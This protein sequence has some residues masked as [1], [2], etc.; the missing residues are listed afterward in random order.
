MLAHDETGRGEPLVLL[1]G[2]GSHRA[3]FA[4]VIG[5]LAEHAS[6]WAIDLPGFGGSPPLAHEAPTVPALAAAVAGF[7]RERG[8][9]SFHVAGNS[10]GGGVALELGR[11]GVARTVCALSPIG[12][13]SGPELRYSRASLR[14]SRALARRLGA[15]RRMLAAT[16]AGRILAG[17]QYFRHPSRIP[18]ADFAA[19][20][21]ALAECPG[22]EATLRCAVG[23]PLERPEALRVPI[24]VAWAEHDRLL[25]TRTQA[26]RARR[27]LPQARHTLLRGCGHVPTYDDPAQVAAVLRA[28]MAARA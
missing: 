15:R 5:H 28:A 21:D 4:P 23:A 27:R 12:F 14:T 18:A 26:G 19:A 11:M 7:L 8:L 9:T 16:P 1:H 3:V 22:F 2:I 24:T 25:P 13:H 10:T 17:A 6:V 20:L